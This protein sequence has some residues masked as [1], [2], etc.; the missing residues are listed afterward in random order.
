MFWQQILNTDHKNISCYNWYQWKCLCH[1]QGCLCIS[2]DMLSLYLFSSLS[3]H[4]TLYLSFYLTCSYWKCICHR[5]QDCSH[6]WNSSLWPSEGWLWWISAL[7]QD[8]IYKRWK[9]LW[10]NILDVIGG[11]HCCL[12]NRNNN[13]CDEFNDHDDKS[14]YYLE[15]TIRE[16]IQIK[17]SLTFGH[18]P[19]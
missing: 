11:Y 12:H 2:N 13:Y 9:H 19:N 16:G 18:C 17:K 3:F 4:L 10:L 1:G 15:H 6:Q 14:K 8:L 5:R 7:L